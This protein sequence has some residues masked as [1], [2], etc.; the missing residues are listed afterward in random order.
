MPLADWAGVPA[1]AG[2]VMGVAFLG[3]GGSCF[4]PKGSRAGLA[5]CSPCPLCSSLSVLCCFV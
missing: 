5:L 2:L 1:D 4:L 3:I